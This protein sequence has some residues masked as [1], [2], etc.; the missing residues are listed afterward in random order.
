MCHS[1]ASKTS[2]SNQVLQGDGDR[3]LLGVREAR[4]VG[5]D[6]PGGQRAPLRAD[7]VQGGRG[8]SLHRRRHPPN[9]LRPREG[10]TPRGGGREEQQAARRH[11]IK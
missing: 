1:Q 10:R 5:G 9:H 11:R 7:H 6:A 3:H 8:D 4:D 2:N